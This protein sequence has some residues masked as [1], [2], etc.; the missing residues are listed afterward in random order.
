MK[1][2][3]VAAKSGSWQFNENKLNICEE[4][5]LSE[6]YTLSLVPRV[7]QGAKPLSSNQGMIWLD[8][9]VTPSLEREGIARDI[10]RLVQQARK[11]AAFDVSD[12]VELELKCDYDLSSVIKEHKK[13]ICDQTLSKFKLGF[14]PDYKT[15]APL[16]E[17]I[18]EIMIK[19][20]I[21]IVPK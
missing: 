14:K 8:L 21:P 13:L 2:I 19:R 3:I 9:E 17:H 7:N 6:E 1:E 20:V 12:R 15:Q 16:C 18:I 10:I 4:E 5:L 11:D